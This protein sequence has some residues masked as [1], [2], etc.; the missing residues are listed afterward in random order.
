MHVFLQMLAQFLLVMSRFLLDEL[1]MMNVFGQLMAVLV[2]CMCHLLDLV[3]LFLL[4]LIAMLLAVL[5][6]LL[7]EALTRLDFSLELGDLRDQVVVRHGLCQYRLLLLLL[8]RFSGVN[9]LVG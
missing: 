6:E 8:M 3:V 4:G 5:L 2:T 1:M 9:A 7:H